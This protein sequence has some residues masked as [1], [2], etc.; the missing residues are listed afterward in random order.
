MRTREIAA[1][2]L[3]TLMALAA[4]QRHGDGTSASGAADEGDP[5]PQRFRVNVL[6]PVSVVPR[7]CSFTVTYLGA[8]MLLVDDG[9]TQL[10]INPFVSRATD[11]T[12]RADDARIDETLETVQATRLKAIFLAGAN[13]HIRDAAY[14][15][16]RTGATVYGPSAS[17]EV[18]RADGVPQQQL[19]AYIPGGAIEVGNF[20][21]APIASMA[22][23]VPKDTS[24]RTPPGGSAT[25][26][27]IRRGTRSI[28]V[29]A[30]TNFVPGALDHVNADVLFLPTGGLAEQSDSFQDQYFRQTVDQVHPE[31]VIPL[32]WDDT[33]RP[34]SHKLRLAE[35]TPAAFD[36]L[37]DR[38][39]QHRIKFGLLQGYQTTELFDAKSCPA[40]L[41]PQG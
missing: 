2:L 31:L 30:S 41:T 28:L 40:P 35:G 13:D 12:T 23:P 10:L 5:I 27:L 26:F 18:A 36:F 37:I 1:C 7:P 4:C 15:A 3:L 38:L 24:G 8:S 29:K 25:D 39:R 21:I 19:A 22:A 17:L 33:A 9:Q 20:R 11:A 32:Q 16:H 6:K 34:L 14:I